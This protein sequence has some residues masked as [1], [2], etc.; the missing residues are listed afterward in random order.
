[1]ASVKDIEG[2]LVVGPSP[3]LRGEESI[4][5][6]MWTVS[7]ALVPALL[8]GAYVF[9]VRSLTVVAVSILTAMATEALLQR[10]MARKITIHDGSAF[11]TG[12]L[13]AF[14][15]PP[16]VRWYV[17]FVGA[18]IAVGLAKHCFGGLGNNIFN[19]ALLGR[20]FVH[21]AF[22]AQMNL[23]DRWPVLQVRSLADIFR[24]DVA[25]VDPQTLELVDAVSRATPLQVLKDNPDLPWEQLPGGYRLID[26]VVGTTPGCLGETSAL[27]LLLGGLVLI[28][29]RHVNWRLPLAYIATVAALIFLLPVPDSTGRLVGGLAAVLRG[30]LQI[31]RVAA[32]LLGGGLFLGAFFMATDMVTSPITGKG[33]ILFGAGA[34]ILVALIRLYGGYPEGVCYSILLMNMTTPL[35]DRYLRP[36]LFGKRPAEEGT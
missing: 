17:P 8:A 20:A 11:L 3:H 29:L 27:A 25:A 5:R 22:P 13:L 36:R 35:I 33:Q 6:I 14:T 4:P 32:H 34:G 23:A 16:N 18:L 28:A 31:A 24:L 19:P 30:D 10:I 1:M 7:A 26:L 9:G 12:L 15:L 21:F 2:K